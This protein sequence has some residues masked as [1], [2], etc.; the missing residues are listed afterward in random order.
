LIVA[1]RDV[2]LQI[3]GH[4]SSKFSSS[5]TSPGSRTVRLFSRTS[6]IELA[7]R[8]GDER[9]CRFGRLTDKQ[10]QPILVFQWMNTLDLLGGAGGFG[11]GEQATLDEEA[12]TETSPEP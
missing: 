8:Y 3:G 11:G 12:P 9:H 1:V 5:C 6:S 10:W 7:R 4:V 2:D